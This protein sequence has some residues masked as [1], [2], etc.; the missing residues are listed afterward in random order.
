MRKGTK[1]MTL[2]LS[3]SDIISGSWSGFCVFLSTVRNFAKSARLD[4]ECR[5]SS[6]RECGSMGSHIL[7]IGVVAVYR[8]AVVDPYKSSAIDQTSSNDTYSCHK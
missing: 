5:I 4:F 3:S 1:M 6:V 8:S 2:I 7:V